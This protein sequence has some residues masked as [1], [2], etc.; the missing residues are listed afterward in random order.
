MRWRA[1]ARQSTQEG[2]EVVCCGDDAVEWDRQGALDRYA[3][4]HARSGTLNTAAWEG[5]AAAG[6]GLQWTGTGT[7]HL[8]VPH[9]RYMRAWLPMQLD[10]RCT[11]SVVAL[12]AVA[13]A[14]LCL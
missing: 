9:S 6:G 11:G 7:F 12:L 13:G 14:L 2:I 8:F 4:R 5:V 3:V 1:S 10:A